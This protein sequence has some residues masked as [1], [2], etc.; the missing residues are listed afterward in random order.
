MS[1]VR[2]ALL[3][4]SLTCAVLAPVAFPLS[5]SAETTVDLDRDATKALTSLYRNHPGAEA[6]SRRARAV[7][8]FPKIVKAGLVFGGAFGEGELRQGALVESYYNSVTASAGL[9]AGVQSYSYV[10]F[11][12]TDKALDYIRSSNGWEIGLGPTIVLLDKGR[13]A[14]LST[15]TVDFNDDAYA[16]VFGQ[17]GIMAGIPLEGTKITKIKQ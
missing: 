12:M 3:A 16:F 8:V 15:S 1:K 13:A 17:S 14:N 6:L 7:L 11:L 9:Q 2:S 5:A 10:V 4:L